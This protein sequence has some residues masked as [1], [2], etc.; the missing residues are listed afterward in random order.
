MTGF[1][2]V[3]YGRSGQ[4]KVTELRSLGV[5]L[6]VVQDAVPARRDAAKEAGLTAY[7]TMD[8]LLADDR[9][10]AVFVATPH[11][12]HHPQALAAIRAGKHVMV[13]K[14]MCLDARE[15]RE[16]VEEARAAGIIF[17]VYHNRRFDE[18]M[19]WVKQSTEN[20]LLGD[21]I[22]VES[23]LCSYRNLDAPGF[24]V[25]E[26][27]RDWRRT[28]KHGGGNLYDMGSHLLDQL[29]QLIPGS[30]E[31]VYGVL[32]NVRTPEGVD[33][34]AHAMFRFSTGI[35]AVLELNDNTQATP[36]RW[37]IDGTKGTLFV[38]KINRGPAWF[39]SH[40]GS[41]QNLAMPPHGRD[42]VMATWVA[43]IRGEGE[44]V[45]SP[46]SALRVMEVMDAI[47]ESARAGQAV[48]REL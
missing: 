48:T 17:S 2:V 1:G 23:R 42:R 15:A 29:L 26:F 12:L 24:G 28:A 11:D 20:G 38:E 46:E 22:A 45:V 10:G 39:L 6:V 21:V 27:H 16:M 14:T 25:S 30:V 43:A 36:P 8:A 4:N 47:R 41:R 44:A 37:R 35:V 32:K 9:V 5:E 34:Y 19:L 7:E 13:E 3:G 40:E 18:D 31:S 33:D